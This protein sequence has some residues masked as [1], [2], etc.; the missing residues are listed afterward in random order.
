MNATKEDNRIK[1]FL[2][3]MHRILTHKATPLRRIRHQDDVY[4]LTMPDLTPGSINANNAIS[5]MTRPQQATELLRDMT[6]ITTGFATRDTTP[7][8]L[9]LLTHRTSGIRRTAWDTLT[10]SQTNTE[11]GILNIRLPNNPTATTLTLHERMSWWNIPHT[12]HRTS[13]RMTAIVAASRNELALQLTTNTMQAWNQESR[14]WKRMLLKQY[15]KE[16][17]QLIHSQ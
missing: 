16:T 13:V 6:A 7:D 15:L 4:I 11:W 3:R 12:N 9:T 1:E 17:I 8:N 2:K 10:P 5:P 14:H